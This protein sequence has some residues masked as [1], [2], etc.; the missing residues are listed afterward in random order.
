M[1]DFTRFGLMNMNMSHEDYEKLTDDE[2]KN[3]DFIYDCVCSKNETIRK[4]SIDM[5]YF[6]FSVIFS[7]KMYEFTEEEIL[8]ENDK[9]LGNLN[10]EDRKTIETFGKCLI[11]SIGLYSK[12]QVKE[13]KLGKEINHEQ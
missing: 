8:D 9:I 1:R 2:K 7:E 10:E 12:D 11:N 3:L 4:S 6:I 13:M 5:M